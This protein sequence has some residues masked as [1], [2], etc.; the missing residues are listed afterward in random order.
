MNGTTKMATATL[1]QNYNLSGQDANSNTQKAKRTQPV[2]ETDT[3]SYIADM[4]LE[5]RNLAKTAGL[6][7]LQGLLEI[8]YYEAFGCANRIDIPEG[9]EQLI[10]ELGADARKA[11]AAAK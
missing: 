7:T 5:L 11:V 6:K 8:S 1:T 2:R 4:I 3:A 10:H 9:E